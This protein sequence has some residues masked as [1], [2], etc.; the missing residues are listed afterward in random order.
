MDW[1]KCVGITTDGARAM[2]GKFS[3]LAARVK[4][5]MP[6]IPWFHCVI[7][8]EA[9]VVKKMSDKLKKTL[10]EAV[11]IVNFIKSRALNSRLFEKLCCDMDSEYKRLLLHAEVRWLSRGKTL[12]RLWQLKDEVRLFLFD[13]SFD[14]ADRMNDASWLSRLAYLSDI[15]T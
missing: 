13:K 6:S 11:K 4:E 15:F 7:H 8:K 12:T 10:D 2:S 9:L 14:L 5:V 3:G 1:S